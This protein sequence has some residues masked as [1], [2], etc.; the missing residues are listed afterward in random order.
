MP[1]FKEKYAFMAVMWLTTYAKENDLAGRFKCCEKTVEQKCKEYC[2]LF[3]SFKDV[4]VRFK[5]FDNRV[6]QYDVDAQNYNTYEFR[7]DPSS[8]WYNHKSH[9]SGVKYEH[10]VYLWE[11]RLVS[12]R[13]PL[14]CGVNDISM[15]KKG[16]DKGSGHKDKGALYFKVKHTNVCHGVAYYLQTTNT[17][18]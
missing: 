10:A 4:K 5:G 7:M 16:G 1:K 13:G 18:P 17:C 15:Y 6:Y 3:Q 11:S 2:K 12:M 9:S 14:P 8:K